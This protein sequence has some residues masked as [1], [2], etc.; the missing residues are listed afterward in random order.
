MSDDVLDSFE[1]ALRSRVVGSPWS[2]DPVDG[3]RS[4]DADVALLDMHVEVR[5]A[6]E[7]RALP[8][9]ET[10]EAGG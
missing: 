5:A 8:L 6:R 7:H 1:T 9:D 2:I 10:E 4:Y 3:A